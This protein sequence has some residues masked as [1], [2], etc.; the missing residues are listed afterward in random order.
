M[1]SRKSPARA[2][3]AAFLAFLMAAACLVPASAAQKISNPGNFSGIDG[4]DANPDVGLHNSYAWC[5]EVFSQADADYLW[6]GM[7][8][9]MGS[10][11][12]ANSADLAGGDM[13]LELAGMPPMDLA[14][15]K[16]K[17]YRQK[18]ADNDAEWEL[19]YENP[20]ISGWRRM[21]VFNGDLY[22]WAGMTNLSAATPQYFYSIIV[23]FK[24]DFQPGDTP[25]IVFWDTVPFDGSTPEYFR[26]AT[27]LDGK[28][29]VGTFDCKIFVTDG[30]GM[31]NQTPLPPAQAPDNYAA[32]HAGWELLLDLTTDPLFETAA[33]SGYVYIRDSIW[34]MIGF[35]GALYVFAINLGFRV[36]KVDAESKAVQIIVGDNAAAKYPSGMGVTRNMSA[37]GFLSASFGKEYVYISTYANGPGVIGNLGLGDMD[38]VL[39]EQFCPAQMYRFDADDNWEV[40]V[41]DTEGMFA[42]KDK[43]SNVL[44]RVGNQRAGFYTGAGAF[45]P[46]MNQYVWWMAEYDGKMYASTWDLGV[47]KKDNLPIFLL[48]N[49][50]VGTLGEEG[51]AIVEALL[52]YA[53]GPGTSI[54]T[55]IG[56]VIKTL[57]VTFKIIR[58][59]FQQGVIRE[60]VPLLI[61]AA[62]MLFNFKNPAGFDL[63][64][65]EDGKNFSPVTVNGFGNQ[66]NYGGRVLLPSKYGM[67]VCTANPFGGGQVWRL[68]DIKPALTINAPARIE[69]E[70]GEAAKVSVQA[71]ALPAGASPVLA[72]VTGGVA[73]AS[74]IKRSEATIYDYNNSISLSSIL[75]RYT[76]TFTIDEYNS[77]MYDIQITGLAPGTETLTFEVSCGGITAACAI[78]VTVS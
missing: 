69:V 73:E 3:L 50:I 45:N 15:R 26:S 32:R 30:T 16:G 59:M 23:R 7:N 24:A 17:I 10:F 76:E 63:F 27:I 72:E 68:D 49:T 46:S 75:K 18:C 21:V 9:D 44:P 34:D 65:S 38:R 66:E 67:F 42:P 60:L 78:E 36:Y 8:R 43:A 41:A 77:E 19:M 20:A 5:T 48:I 28:L 47:F 71:L 33:N 74:L 35:N 61:D 31:S 40:I 39:N 11:L 2:A 37:S 58:L 70:A 55:I 29:Y 13:M 52:P 6:V 1:K 4:I 62:K 25:E 14:D 22:V 57:P 54:F 56:N 53:F 64:V 51:P 12:V